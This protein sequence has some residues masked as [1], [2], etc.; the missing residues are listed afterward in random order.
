MIYPRKL[1]AAQWA[2][3]NIT[4][5]ADEIGIEKDTRKQ[6]VGDGLTRWNE[7]SYQFNKPV[8]DA[9]YAPKPGGSGNYLTLD[10]NSKV[11]ETNL[12][13]RLAAAELNSTFASKSVEISKLDAS[14]KGSASGVA[15][16]GSD[17]KLLETN[18]PTRLADT[19]LNAT[20]VGLKQAAKN[21]DLLIAGAVTLDGSDQVTS[22]AVQWPDGSPGTLTIT[23]RHSTGAV[24]NY[25]ITYGSPVTKT[26]TQPTITRNA[27]GTATNVPQIVV[28]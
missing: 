10:S 27:N 21:P 12:P 1:T 25:N 9:V 5:R 19:S 28:S 16:L 23:A 20:Y 17:S 13:T 15:A 24:T 14:Q 2:E 22:S 7:L 3:E 18:I 26:F 6:K 11:P 4:L 8:A